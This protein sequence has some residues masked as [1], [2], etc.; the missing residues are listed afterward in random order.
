MRSLVGIVVLSTV[1]ALLGGTAHRKNEEGNRHYGDGSFDEALQAYT[2]AQVAAPEAP[3]LHYDIGNVLY[4][5]GKFPGAEEAFARALSSGLPKI[6]RD[7]AYNLGN[8]YFRQERY[9]D[10]VRAYR[11]ALQTSPADV[12][13]KRNL[14]M[15]LRALRQQQEPKP[16]P[17]PRPGDKDKQQQP[18][19]QQQQQQQGRSNGQGGGAGPSPPPEPS[20]GPGEGDPRDGAKNAARPRPRPGDMTPD[21]AQRLLD[22]LGEQERDNVRKNAARRAAADN[23]RL[24]KDW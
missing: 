7:A 2:E 4:K 18:Q 16:S 13:S 12:D 24:E 11:K 1:S 3:E 10:A 17:E 8:A 15:A 9:E 22:R 21:E 14:E 5:Q 6:S 19:Q 23:S 20:P